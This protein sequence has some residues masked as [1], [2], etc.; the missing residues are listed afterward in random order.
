[1]CQEPKHLSSPASTGGLGIHFENRIQASFVVLMLS[2]GFAPC[3]N[4]WPITKIKL[5]GR[6]QNYNTDDFIVYTKEPGTDIEVKL[7]CQIKLSI[8]ITKGDKEF[9]EVIQAA[10]NDFN[11]RDVFTEGKDAI[12]LIS[13]P[14]SWRDTK[15]VRDLL[16]QAKHSEDA[17]DFIKRVE[18]GK[19]TSEQQRDKFKVFKH[20]LR[21]ANGNKDISDEEL[22]RFLKSYN[23]LIYDLDI[24][25]VVLSLLYSLI[26]QYSSENPNAL[27]AQV[28]D[29]V[30]W[31]SE[32]AGVI[33]N[34]SIPD[35]I[36]SAFDKK[37]T[38]TISSGFSKPPSL[39]EEIDWNQSQYASEL[40]ITILLGSWY[41]KSDADI[42]IASQLAKEEYSTWISNIREIL[43]PPE[44][45]ITLDD[46]IWKVDER[47]EL[48][49]A[50]GP[51]LFDDDLDIFKQCVV[52][53]LTERDPMFDLPPED[54]YAASVHGKVL[55][56]SQYL[57]KGLSESIALL[58][59]HPG[60]LINCSSNKPETIVV[61]AVREIFEDTDWKL[62]GSLNKLLPLFAEAA[63]NEFINI[64]ET[65]L[66]KTP[67]PFDQ[68]FSQKNSG[69]TGRNYMSGLL[70]ALETLAWDERYL[71]RVTIVLGE[72]AV[73]DPG[74]NWTNR[75][76]NSLTTIF[77]PWI[78]QTTAS[79]EKRQVAIRTLQNEFPDI[80]WEILLS[81]LPKKHQVSTGSHRPIWRET[82]PE[83]WS[84][85]VSKDEYWNQVFC[86]ADML[87]DIAKKDTDRLTE[88]VEN[89]D[90]LPP[91]NRD[92]LLR[93][94]VSDDIVNMPED[95]RYLIWNELTDLTIRHKR[96][97]EAKRALNTRTISKI[98]EV[99]NALK[100]S[101][102]KYI[103]RRLF[104]GRDYELFEER[105][106]WKEQQ[107]LME[108]HRQQ[109]IKEILDEG[110]ID[111]VLQFSE[112]VIS[113]SDVGYSLGFIAEAEIDRII[114]PNMLE[115]ERKNLVQLAS[116]YVCGRYHSQGWAWVDQIDLTSWSRTQ[117]GVLLTYLPFTSETWKR[118]SKLLD[119]SEAEYWCKANV[120]PHQAD[121][122]LLF[123]I[124]KLIEYERPNAAIN[125]LSTIIHD[126]QPL[127]NSRVVKALLSA[128]SSDEPSHTMDAYNI[129]ELIKALQE[130]PDTKP[131]DLFAVEWAYLPLIEKYPD[132][133]PKF[134][135][136]ILAND[137]VFFCEV[138][139]NIYR[140]DKEQQSDKEPTE[141]EIAVANNAWG[142]LKEW[143]TP[144][145]MDSNGNFSESDFN[146]WLESVKVSCEESGHLDVA[147]T[148]VGNVLIHTPADP[149]GLWIN[150]VVAEALNSRDGQKMRNGFRIGLYNSRGVYFIDPTGKPEKELAAKYREK[151]D[152]VENAG[153]QRLA[154]TLRDLA[155]SYEKEAERLASRAG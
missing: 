135:E 29:K 48:W 13:G 118:V 76:A 73:H 89:L 132:A 56:H 30:Q 27:W 51:R 86:Y 122:E 99:A 104:S 41:E 6:Y 67:C 121:R 50:L 155:D 108:E 8:S 126:K 4:T 93:Y 22:Y 25:G 31:E 36:R 82:I 52:N 68:L 83:D 88:L 142:L 7:L 26:G 112:N 140:S 58:G 100:P 102:P 65:E 148:K 145:G 78:P 133:S 130:D 33:T 45:P 28:M 59:S 17:D 128:V 123:A 62:W 20:H 113:S 71:S 1:M 11:D 37:T 94:L 61:S 49:Q 74:G 57:R 44:T 105:G 72:L 101:N 63:P 75:P 117:I 92:E 151:A 39:Q 103:H 81:L 96:H 153:Y 23:L 34:N 42:H 91:P 46:G 119:D 79:V 120:N 21:V 9:G 152:K 114:L 149:D 66:Q 77:L 136:N 137:P 10:W 24:K 116:G 125:C 109:A 40:A 16:K 144:P 111:Y 131:N 32:N 127:D 60:A 90:N 138:I 154:V 107:K 69:I 98:E 134:L 139:R 38:I 47:K 53:V 14:L 115:T 15:G 43:Q 141:D 129:V 150:N 147:L 95:E 143:K 12:A 87:V 5:Q 54:R 19:F 70:W 55:K 35:E 3:L 85:E 124:D 84:K 2:G 106:S 146:Q 80:A 97:L 18:L 64:I 110:G